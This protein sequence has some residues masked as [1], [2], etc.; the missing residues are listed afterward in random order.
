MAKSSSDPGGEF[1]IIERYFAPLAKN[2]PGAFDLKDDAGLI[3]PPEGHELVLTADMIVSGVHYLENAAP[4]DIAYKALAVNVSDLC[5][6]GATP[7]VYLLSLALPENPGPDWLESLRQ[8]FADAQA[9]FGCTLLGGD[10]V[11]TPG[12]AVLSIT[13]A[14]FV[15]TG[16]MVHRMGAK[17]GDHV[18]A[19][20]TI[21]DAAL[22]LIVLRDARKAETANLSEDQ[23]SFLH[24]RYWRPRPRIEAIDAILSHANAA[25]DIS[26]GLAGDFSKL[27]A[28]SQTGGSIDAASV[29]LSDAVQQWVEA[30]P[31]RLRDILTG[32]DDY[33][34]LV[35]VSQNAQDQFESDCRNSGVS[36]KCIGRILKPSKSVSVVGKDGKV[37]TL[38]KSGYEH[39]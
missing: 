19:T 22:G 33:E 18:Y 38:E 11:S 8:G 9:D 7:S 21:G 25:M 10:T 27:C 14:G 3:S 28:A 26:D 15:P 4:C 30:E 1:G 5:A 32:G 29:P 24:N 23:I 13:A 17:P 37:L 34:L 39:F 6:K 16:Q 20:G 35:T 2:T 36:V 12:P 31:K